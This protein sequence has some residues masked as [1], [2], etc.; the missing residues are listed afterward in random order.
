MRIFTEWAMRGGA[1]SMA[2]SLY[3]SPIGQLGIHRCRDRHWFWNVAED[4]VTS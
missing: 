1:G 4:K 3:L 2:N